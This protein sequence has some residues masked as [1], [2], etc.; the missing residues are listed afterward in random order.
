[1]L[2]RHARR[3][4]E[5]MLRSSRK[6]N[7]YVYEFR[8]NDGLCISSAYIS[9]QFLLRWRASEEELSPLRPALGSIDENIADFIT[10]CFVVMEFDSASQ[11]RACETKALQSCLEMSGQ[12][13]M[14][15]MSH[16]NSKD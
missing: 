12:R 1:M 3:G 4:R 9:T 13:K 2:M 10:S 8:E 15:E 16:S 5:R 14:P 6:W 11:H 7:E